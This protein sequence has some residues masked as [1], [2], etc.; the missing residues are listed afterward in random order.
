MSV[1]RSN[2]AVQPGEDGFISPIYIFAE[3][4]CAVINKSGPVKKEHRQRLSEMY[5]FGLCRFN[6]ILDL[7]DIPLFWIIKKDL[8]KLERVLDSYAA[9]AERPPG[10]REKRAAWGVVKVDKILIGKDELDSA[11]CVVRPGIL[12]QGVGKSAVKIL[13][14]VY[15]CSGNDSALTIDYSDI[16]S[17]W[18][19]RRLASG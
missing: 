16:R 7:I 4:D 6:E 11:Q 1:L 12:A 13:L 17:G 9:G 19:Q 15:L 2:L 14:P 3:I 10:S 5:G 18:S 8:S